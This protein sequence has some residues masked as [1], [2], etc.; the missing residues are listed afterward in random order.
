[1]IN[2]FAW[3][4]FIIPLIS[5]FFLS[6]TVIRRYISVALLV[7]VMNVILYE[8]AWGTTGGDI[9]SLFSVGTE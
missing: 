1:M 6:K 2:V 9:V 4:I 3:L 8:I 7:T 5:L